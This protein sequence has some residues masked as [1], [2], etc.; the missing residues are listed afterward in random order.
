MSFYEIVVG[1]LLDP[2]W[3][4]VL[5]AAKI[6]HLPNGNTRL[7]CEMMDQAELYATISRLRDMNM[8]LI[9]VRERTSPDAP[10]DD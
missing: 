5:R 10:G 2:R 4:D 8:V 9:S 6:E 3:R 1:S 7:L